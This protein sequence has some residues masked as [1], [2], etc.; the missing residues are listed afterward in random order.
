VCLDEKTQ[1]QALSRTQPLLPLRAGLLAR[2]THD[3]RRNGVTSLFAALESLEVGCSG[4]AGPDTPG[5]TSWPSPRRSRGADLH[6]ILDKLLEPQDPSGAGLAGGASPRALSFH[7]TGASWL[8]MIEAWF[9]VLTQEHP[10]RLFRHGAGLGA[11]YPRIPG[12][13]ERACGPLH[14]DQDR[15][16]DHRQSG[17]SLA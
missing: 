2:Q 17:A 15:G 11:A 6:F 1:I 10:P 9:S 3:Y 14:L 16:A 4:S 5:R 12:A 7:P 8:N 13:V